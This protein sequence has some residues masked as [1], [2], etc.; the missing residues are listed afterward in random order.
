MP[1]SYHLNKLEAADEEADRRMEFAN[2]LRPIRKRKK[3]SLRRRTEGGEGRKKEKAK[4]ESECPEIL[5]TII[6]QIALSSGYRW[7]TKWGEN[8]E[9]TNERRRKDVARHRRESQGKLILLH[10]D[11]EGSFRPSL[12]FSWRLECVAASV[13]RP[14]S[15]DRVKFHRDSKTKTRKLGTFLL[16]KFPRESLFND[17]V[18]R[19]AL[20][21]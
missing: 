10:S 4:E 9:K 21:K 12:P 3:L 16:Y 5:F 15:L 14:L 6:I 1:L 17:P 18:V 20:R 19:V 13:A 11:G 7:P 8:S 2:A